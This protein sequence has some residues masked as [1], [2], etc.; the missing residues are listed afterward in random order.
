M[1]KVVFFKIDFKRYSKFSTV[2][3]TLVYYVFFIYMTYDI[4][5][6]I[7]LFRMHLW[8]ALALFQ[9]KT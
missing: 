1:T 2:L 6:L 7:C 8:V 5:D 9:I 4:F 3:Q